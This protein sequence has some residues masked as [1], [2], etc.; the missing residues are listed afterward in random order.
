MVQPLRERAADILP[1]A[2][3]LLAFFARAAGRPQQMKLS[4]EAEAA[5]LTYAWP[6]N[7]RELRN[8]MGSPAAICRTCGCG[9]AAHRGSLSPQRSR[10]RCLPGLLTLHPTAAGRTYAAYGGVYISLAV[11]WL[12]PIDGR[13]PDRSDLLGAAFCLFGMLTILIAPR[14]H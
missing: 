12:W 14:A 5:L 13:R 2:R 8:I 6:G 1:L 10:S 9:V 7:I 11:L 4:K 3:R